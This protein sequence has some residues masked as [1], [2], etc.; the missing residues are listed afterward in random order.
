MR[1]T[2]PVLAIGGI[3]LA[4]RVL[5]NDQPMDWTIP[6]ATGIAV[7]A[8]SLFEHAAGDAAPALAWLAL[9][10][11]LLSRIDPTVPSPVESLFEWWKKQK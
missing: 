4:N 2:G 8:F 1:S 5:L 6:I 11:V 10:T 7:G 3:T 9:A